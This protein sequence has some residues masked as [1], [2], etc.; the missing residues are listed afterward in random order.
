MSGLIDK[1][2]ADALPV[3]FEFL[4]RIGYDMKIA[5]W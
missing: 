4:A 5:D 1:V 2:D 3:S